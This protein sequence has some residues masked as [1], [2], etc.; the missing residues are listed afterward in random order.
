[1]ASAIVQSNLKPLI[2]IFPL[3]FKTKVKGKKTEEDPI[4]PDFKIP[5]PEDPTKL[6]PLEN[7]DEILKAGES[8]KLI[9]DYSPDYKECYVTIVEAPTWLIEYLK[10]K[11]GRPT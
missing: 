11:V 10:K 3:T 8:A 2:C 7:L 5:H 4:R 9:Y 6:I 1:V